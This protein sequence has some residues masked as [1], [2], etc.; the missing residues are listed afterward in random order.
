MEEHEKRDWE[1]AYNG[2]EK[3]LILAA[4]HLETIRKKKL[5]GIEAELRRELAEKIRKMSVHL[6]DYD[7]S[8]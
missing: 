6:L 1:E 3:M 4:I 2:A 7:A 5:T 8:N